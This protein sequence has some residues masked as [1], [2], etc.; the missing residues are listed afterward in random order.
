ML[1]LVILCFLLFLS[2]WVGM[3]VAASLLTRLCA[4]RPYDFFCAVVVCAFFM[5][6][7]RFVV[8]I[9]LLSR[10]LLPSTFCV[11]PSFRSVFWPSQ[12][13]VLRSVLLPL[14]RRLA[15]P[16]LMSYL[17]C[18]FPYLP[19]SVLVM[20]TSVA[21]ASSIVIW[22][23][24]LTRS[25]LKMDPLRFPFLYVFSPALDMSLISPCSILP[26]RPVL[27]FLY[28]SAIRLLCS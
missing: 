21:L 20:F 17:M 18:A 26:V 8:Y 15:S 16:S 10:A 14:S 4:C 19:L 22:C 9:Y 24:M 25:A 13:F 6:L 7:H 11:G 28:I 1:P 3:A 5:R 2:R 23:M 12:L 27:L